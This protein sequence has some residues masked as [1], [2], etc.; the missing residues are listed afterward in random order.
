M[1]KFVFKLAAV[2]RHRELVEQEKLRLFSEAQARLKALE[3][4]L[5]DLQHAV[6]E[7]NQDLR[8]NR[9]VGSLDV[10]FLISHRRFLLGMQRKGMEMV[11]RIAQAQREAAQA[12]VALAEA[13]RARKVLEKLRERQLERWREE[14]ARKE[15][16]MLDEVGG[17]LGFEY[18]KQASDP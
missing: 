4:E 14:Q 2:L 18:I 5:A 12:Q 15:L 17:Q 7:A 3:G 1:A 8:R 6:E 10:T 9:L 11:G 16:A 13:A